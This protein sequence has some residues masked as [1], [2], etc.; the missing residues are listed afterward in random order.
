MG[1][2]LV[3]LITVLSKVLKVSIWGHQGS[4]VWLPTTGLGRY[5]TV[6]EQG[7]VCND[8][9]DRIKSRK[10]YS[11][12][13]FRLDYSRKGIQA[14]QGICRVEQEK[15]DMEYEIISYTG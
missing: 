4:P 12:V 1:Q 13:V 6:E 14:R 15:N 10:Y 3:S 11:Q 5:V 8:F 2:K 7:A 9:G